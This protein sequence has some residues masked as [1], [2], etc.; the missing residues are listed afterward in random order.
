MKLLPTCREVTHIVSAGL[1]RDLG[2]MERVRLRMH[3]SLCSGCSHFTRHMR[4]IRT[5]MQR[6]SDTD[7]D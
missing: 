1:D 4:L 3:L 7:R 6:M 5:A 2:T